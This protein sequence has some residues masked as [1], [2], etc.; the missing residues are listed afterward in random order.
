MN[1]C[2]FITAPT[3]HESPRSPIVLRMLPTTSQYRTRFPPDT[4]S[5]LPPPAPMFPVIRLALR[6]VMHNEIGDGT[7]R[8]ATKGADGV[9]LHLRLRRVEQCQRRVQRGAH[10]PHLRGVRRVVG[11]RFQQE[12]IGEFF[13]DVGGG[14]GGGRFGQF[15]ASELL[16]LQV[17]A[18]KQR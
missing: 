2:L 14:C 18:Q 17:L 11:G 6:C 13:L 9:L 12:A 4:P 5:R 15:L 10:G 1:A 3:E 8:N 16:P 7:E